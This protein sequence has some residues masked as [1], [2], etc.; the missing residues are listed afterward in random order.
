MFQVERRKQKILEQQNPSPVLSGVYATSQA[1][2]DKF[3]TEVPKSFPTQNSYAQLHENFLYISK[4][5]HLYRESLN[6]SRSTMLEPYCG[7]TFNYV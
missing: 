5:E 2:F 7:V 3:R 6:K 1:E 4:N